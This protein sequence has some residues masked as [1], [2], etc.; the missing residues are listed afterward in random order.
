MLGADLRV[1]D[2]VQLGSVGHRIAG[3]S[4]PPRLSQRSAGS[5]E[6]KRGGKGEEAEGPT[7]KRKQRRKD[8]CAR[9][10]GFRGGFLQQAFIRLLF[11]S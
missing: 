10:R 8:R 9:K 5:Y 6:Q 1:R 3:G 7:C 2:T 11:F 4:R